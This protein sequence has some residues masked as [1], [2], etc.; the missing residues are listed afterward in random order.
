MVL[1]YA[2][3]PESV[4]LEDM[5]EIVRP[6]GIEL[7]VSL[8][9]RTMW[10]TG[11]EPHGLQP[12]LLARGTAMKKTSVVWG[13]VFLLCL[14]ALPGIEYTGGRLCM[15]L[16]VPPLFPAQIVPVGVGLLAGG[17]THWCAHPII[18]RATEPSVDLECTGHW[19]YCNG[20]LWARRAAPA[21][22]SSRSQRPLHLSRWVRSDA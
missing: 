16:I 2:L 11:P 21:R 4:T 3:G 1:S 7:Q 5:A 10:P 8:P 22:I 9:M 6:C 18:R 17:Q 15:P 19:H 13:M 12:I 14:V 20:S